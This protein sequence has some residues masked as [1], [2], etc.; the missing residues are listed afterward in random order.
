MVEVNLLIAFGAGLLAFL[1][2]CVLPLI[3]AF[4]A[5][6]A[7]TTVTEGG[8]NNEVK[9]KIIFNTIFF[10]LGFAFVFAVIGALLNSILIGLSYDVR[11]WLGR[12]GGVI[13]IFFGL[14]LVG[15]L[16][17]PFLEQEYKLRAK[18]TRFQYLTSFL[19]GAT[20]AAGW[21]PC[22]GVFLG[23]ILT[24]AITNPAIAFPLL[25]SF[26]LGLTLPFFITGIFFSQAVDFVKNSPKF[27]K[28]FKIISGLILII[29]GILVFTNNLSKLAS[30][31]ALLFWFQNLSK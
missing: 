22:V 19:F 13:I 25:L 10:C 23:V 28:Y 6:M 8:S 9:L 3:P 16:K 11:V 29:L 2:P 31:D 12:I 18:K 27:M 14:F 5:Y 26:A 30:F 4:L 17:I 21:T 24:L 20:F 7:G 15:L 1:S